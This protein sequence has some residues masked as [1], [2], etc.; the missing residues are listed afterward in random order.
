MVAG[1]A[2]DLFEIPVSIKL[3]GALTVVSGIVVATTCSAYP[4]RSVSMS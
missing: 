1:G 4:S 2:A 3:V